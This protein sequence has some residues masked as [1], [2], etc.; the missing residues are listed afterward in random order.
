MPTVVTILAIRAGLRDAR[1]GQA[2]FLWAI[3]A[4]PVERRR[5]L[6]SAWKDLGRILVVALVLDTAY[7]VFVLRRF[8]VVHALIVAVAC[9]IVPYA[10]FRGPITRLTRGLYRK[11]P[12]PTGMPA[13]NT[14]ENAT[15]RLER[16]DSAEARRGD[17][18][19]RSTVFEHAMRTAKTERGNDREAADSRRK[20]RQR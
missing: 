8:Y 20:Q 17:L 9:T 14:T 6:R 13:A 11:Q 2:A 18:R 5:L 4:S 19:K 12:R 10:L 7:Q 15:G 16:R 3:L 1:E